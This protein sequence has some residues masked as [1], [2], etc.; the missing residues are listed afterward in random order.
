MDPFGR[1]P[2]VV[3]ALLL[4]LVLPQAE[5]VEARRYHKYRPL[6]PPTPPSPRS[7]AVMWCDCE[8]CNQTFAP[9]DVSI[10][11]E[12]E[13][14]A[15]TTA[16]VPAPEVDAAT[17]PRINRPPKTPKPPSPTSPAVLWCDCAVCNNRTFGAESLPAAESWAPT[18]AAAVPSQ[19][20]GFSESSPIPRLCVSFSN[21]SI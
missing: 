17:R 18:T 8:L 9:E 20:G 4:L 3:A 7:P 5:E 14:W 19:L 16:A 11:A 2:L 1:L 12:A 21:L 6:P 10:A 15:P 13:P